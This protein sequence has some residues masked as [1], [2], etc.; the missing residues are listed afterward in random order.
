M[1]LSKP[2]LHNIIIII[3][4]SSFEKT[5]L[6]ALEMDL[7]WVLG[8]ARTT[9][10][11]SPE[12]T[13][14]PLKNSSSKSLR[15][16]C[17]SPSVTPPC[18]LTPFLPSGHLKTMNS[19]VTKSDVPIHYRRKVFDSDHPSY[20]G[21]FVVD[22]VSHLDADTNAKSAGDADEGKRNPAKTRGNAYCPKRTRLFEEQEW[23]ELEAG[24]DDT[25]PMLVVLHGLSGGS[26]EVYLKDVLA[27]LTVD[28]KQG[29]QKWEACVVTA[30]G[31]AG[32]AITSGVLFNATATWDCRQVVKWLRE[33]F[34]NRPLF[35]L[36]FS[37]GANILVNV[38]ALDFDSFDV[39]DR[40]HRI[41]VKPIA[42]DPSVTVVSWRRRRWLWA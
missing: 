23:V 5:Q 26:Y 22:F 16:F 12:T 38:G 6:S 18:R 37:L 1:A 10:H 15:D 13:L 32:S 29:Q 9:F 30:R 17:S 4:L 27:P 11:C 28:T 25:T 31:C 39:A 40:R 14:L 19:V 34:P 35:G 41:P 8:H 2:R 36:G 20:S 33:R 42:N 7:W 3:R 21:T 24:S